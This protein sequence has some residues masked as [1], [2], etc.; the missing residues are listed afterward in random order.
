MTRTL[1]F[2]CQLQDLIQFYKTKTKIDSIK[3]PY[4]CYGIYSIV[5]TMSRAAELEANY[6]HWFQQIN[7]IVL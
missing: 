6:N 4:K 1:S 5:C 3:L 2:S 7:V